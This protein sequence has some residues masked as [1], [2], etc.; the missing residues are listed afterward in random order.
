MHT[1]TPRADAPRSPSWWRHASLLFIAAWVI[2][3][4]SLPAN[5]GRSPSNAFNAPDATPLG[6]LVQARRAQAGARSDSGFY[7]LDSVDAAF[8]SRLALIEGAQRSLDL[9]YYAIHADASTEIPV[10]Y[11]HLTLPTNRE[12]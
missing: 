10:S 12:V 9:Q 2:G 5:S 1:T 11:T 8:T 6:Q 4:A 3:C 7:L